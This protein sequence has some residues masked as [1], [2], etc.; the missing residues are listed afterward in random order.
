[1]LD[2]ALNALSHGLCVMP[3]IE[4]G[5]KQPLGNSLTDRRWK[6]FQNMRPSEKQIRQWYALGLTNIGYVTGKVSNNLEVIDFDDADCYHEFKSAAVSAGL[7]YLVEKIESGYTEHTPKGVHWF[8]RCEEISGNTKLAS[9]LKE[10]HEMRD[11][12][13]KVQVMIET[14]G[15]GGFIIAAPSRGAVNPNGKYELIRGGVE[16]IATITPQERKD[17]FC[18]ADTFDMLPK[19]IDVADYN[20]SSDTVLGKPGEEFAQSV[21]WGEILKP[22]GWKELHTRNGVTYWQRPGKDDGISASTNYQNSGLFYVWSTSTVFEPER[23]YNKFAV[24]TYL[25]HH[26]DFSSAAK[27]LAAEGFGHETETET[28][29]LKFRDKAKD[30]DLNEIPLDLLNIPG[31]VNELQHW[32]NATAIRQ[33]PYLAFGAALAAAGVLMVRKVRTHTG[34]GTNFLIIALGD[35]AC[36]KNEPRNRIKQL[37]Q[38]AGC[39]NLLGSENIGSESGLLDDLV[40][41]GGTAL[42]QLDEIGLMLKMMTNKKASAY[43]GAIVPTLMR[44]QSNLGHKWIG[45]ALAKDKKQGYS[46]NDIDDPCV[47]V[48][49]TS[50]PD[51]YFQAIDYGNIEDG[52]VP[53]FMIFQSNNPLPPKNYNR[54]DGGVPDALMDHV[55]RWLLPVAYSTNPISRVLAQS[56]RV[57]GHTPETL[58]IMRKF[59]KIVDAQYL[60]HRAK[61]LHAVWGRVAA[62]A[63]Q[64]A[65]LITCSNDSE[66]KFITERAATHACS[67]AMHLARQQMLRLDSNVSNN[68]FEADGKQIENFI[69]DHRDKGVAK[70]SITLKFRHIKPNELST[71]LV[72][73]VNIGRVVAQ[74]VKGKTKPTTVYYSTNYI[75]LDEAMDQTKKL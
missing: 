37:F 63:E 21:E 36:G 61:R 12:H 40:H 19:K 49:G 7:G 38:A 69:K 46:R 5:K 33:Q 9:R 42:Y 62:N 20:G 15:E 43:L 26:G 70:T 59:D 14:R 30:E 53:R 50:V 35:S 48:Y 22:H 54:V 24:Y 57:V 34:L 74:T 64:L 47:V 25:E 18:L 68:E 29:T 45:K 23:G 72:Q 32:F 56:P 11:A 10:P 13:D 39:E 55:Q 16:T 52:F 66:A 31:L 67:L 2:Y 60:A 1:M 71:I 41:C 4:D 17:L 6:H 73:L 28:R 65:L 3:A 51:K 58:S 27:A 75:D 8:Y 44:L